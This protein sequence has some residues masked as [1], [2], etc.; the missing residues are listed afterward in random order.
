MQKNLLSLTSLK[1]K[2]SDRVQIS[3]NEGPRNCG[4][5]TRASPGRRKS[6]EAIHYNQLTE[7]QIGHPRIR[8]FYPS[9]LSRAES[10]EGNTKKRNSGRAYGQ[11]NM[12]GFMRWILKKR[13]GRAMPG[14]SGLVRRDVWRGG[15]SLARKTDRHVRQPFRSSI[16]LHMTAKAGA[17]P[18]W[19]WQGTGVL[20]G[21]RVSLRIDLKTRIKFAEGIPETS[22]IN[23]GNN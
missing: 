8:S 1:A 12:H 15:R 22:I 13:A 17:L 11:K 16:W 4:N 2:P 9:E 10:L 19:A 6:L 5:E 23:F 14:S 18:T 20:V 3:A 7:A 21:S